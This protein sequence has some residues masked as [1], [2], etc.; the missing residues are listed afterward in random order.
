MSEAAEEFHFSPRANRASEINWHPWSQEAFDEARHTGRPILLSISA[1]WCH[2][3]HVMDETTYSHPGVIDIINREY[4]PVRVDNDVRPDINQRYNMGGWPTT[5]FLTASGDI[6]TGGTYLPPDQMATRLIRVGDSYRANQADIASRVLEARKRAASGVARSVGELEPGL[7]DTILD[8]V[9]SAYDP[10]YGGFGNAPKFPQADAIL[11][12][13]EQSVLRSDPEL[14]SMAVHT[15]EQ[16]AGG[17]TYDHVEGGFFRYSTTQDWSVPHFEKMLEDH[18]GLVG[19]L[20]LAGMRDQ[21]DATTGYL[22][23][24]LRDPA[25]GL[26]AGS[27]DADETYYSLDAEGRARATAPYVDHRVYTSWNAALAISYLDAAIRCDRPALREH[28]AALLSSLFG[29]RYTRS[30][31]LAHAEGVAGQL[32]DQAWGLWAAVRAHESGLGGQWLEQARDLAQHLEDR[33]ADRELGGYFD[34]AG[35]D[36]LGRLSEPIKPL[37]E[38]SIA[39]MAL[40][41][42]HELVGDPKRPYLNRA[43]RTLESVAALP[44]PYGLMA[45]VLAPALDRRNHNINVNT[46]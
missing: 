3:C 9:K 10:E 46:C 39:A 40:T 5:A 38:N 24:V 16:M 18:A 44:H 27:Q 29:E 17:G 25:T 20:A 6:L 30:G 41:E 13:L 15:L 34:H 42:L 4:V 37:A 14:R 45:A 21:L 35:A 28:A 11:L 26:Y 1:V 32:P 43:R 23:H 31:G 7:V 36:Q 8:A 12:L 33:Y 2:W 19:G 22:D